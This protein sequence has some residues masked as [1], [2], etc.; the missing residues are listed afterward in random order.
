M[1]GR[2]TNKAIVLALALATVGAAFMAQLV[3]SNS[4]QQ[5]RTHRL[6]SAQRQVLGAVR[7]RTFLLEDVADMV[8]VHD[9]ADVTEFSRYAHVRG[10]D[11]RSV[12]SVQWVRRSP[13]GRLQPPAETGPTPLL[14]QPQDRRDS[15]LARTTTQAAAQD[16]LRRASLGRDVGISHPIALANGH[17]GFYLAVPVQARARA[18]LVS[19]A[20]SRSAIVGLIDAQEM[21]AQAVDRS[22]SPAVRLSDGSAPLGGV[23]STPDNAR[24]TSVSVADQRWML[25]VA[26][27][28]PTALER[29]APWLIVLLGLGLAAAVALVLRT[30]A[31]RRDD[32]LR[33]ADERSHDLVATLQRVELANHD[34]ELA[35]AEADRRSR[36]DA[37]TG[38][39]NRRHFGEVLAEEFAH[40]HED[41]LRAAVLLLDLDHFKQV[42]DEHGHLTGDAVLRAVAGRLGTVLRSTDTL[43]RWGGE[44]FA[45]LA[46]GMDHS[47]MCDLAERA[48]QALGS[49]PIVVGDTTLQLRTSVGAALTGAE[50]D[51]PDQVVGAADKALYEAK[52]AGRDRTRVHV[53]A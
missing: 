39:S 27:G 44:E 21:L 20:E 15:A 32:A 28:S 11:D 36:E 33:L 10:R 1:S 7:A 12:V 8:G 16:A 38:I 26:G 4:L 19:R 13:D 34:L 47:A 51:T 40:E 46:P 22:I 31:R 53:A 42:N 52:R 9:D 43:A 24:S 17:R 25:T 14:I 2:A 45:I 37:L 41:G 29:L 48:R 3:V 18:G 49:R 23:G 5:R 35:R 6:E 30:A 50:L